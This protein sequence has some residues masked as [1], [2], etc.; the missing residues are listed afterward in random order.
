MA[1]K[2]A[3]YAGINIASSL[4]EPYQEGD[5]VPICPFNGE[6]CHKIRRNEKPV[7]SIWWNDR[8]WISCEHRLL[9]PKQSVP[10]THDH[11][12]TRIAEVARLLWG[13]DIPLDQLAIA[14][15]LPILMSKADFVFAVN[16]GWKVIALPLRYCM[17]VQ[18]GGIT[19]NTGVI[20][21]H[22]RRWES[23]PEEVDPSA[24]LQ[25]VRPDDLGVWKRLLEQLFTK[26]LASTKARQ[27][28]GCIVGDTLFEQIEGRIGWSDLE[29]PE[30]GFVDF[31]VIPYKVKDASADPIEIEPDEERIIR[32]TFDAF[33]EQLGQAGTSADFSGDY[34]TLEGDDVRGS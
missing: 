7:C 6:D 15:Q 3:E 29:S 26:G 4:P 1:V 28:I 9:S 14:R 34:V 31:V 23:N 10:I 12:S 18:G 24:E 20:T 2:V 27:G 25:G 8:Y 13:D 16:P 32:T 19:Q 21:R 5:P 17:E 22:L 11:V 30:D 33:V